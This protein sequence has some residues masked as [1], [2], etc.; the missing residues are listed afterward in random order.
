MTVSRVSRWD[1]EGHANV[2]FRTARLHQK[3]KFCRCCSSRLS[4]QPLPTSHLGSAKV[5]TANCV[6]AN[7][8][9][10]S[11]QLALANLLAHRSQFLLLFSALYA[12]AGLRGHPIPI[13]VLSLVETRDVALSRSCGQGRAAWRVWG[14]GAPTTP[15]GQ[16]GRPAGDNHR[17][18]RRADHPRRANQGSP[19]RAAPGV[20]RVYEQ[21]PQA[22]AQGRHA[23]A[24]P[25]GPGAGDVVGVARRPGQAVAAGEALP[26]RPRPPK[27]QPAAARSGCGW[28]ELAAAGRS[29][30]Q[31]AEPADAR[32][33]G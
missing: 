6:T 29:R 31:R 22:A 3:P 19:G 18:C 16:D 2:G 11:P 10:L 13:A 21:R 9:H 17:A 27:G 23:F 12:L 32:C 24:R 20:H 8:I 5:V 25:G 30:L 7:A 1:R 4:R 14:Q 15:D 28:A 33:T 26:G